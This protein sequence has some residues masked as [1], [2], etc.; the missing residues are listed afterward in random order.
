M[1]EARI[2]EV[3]ELLKDG[4]TDRD[5]VFRKL[6]ELKATADLQA[7]ARGFP[8]PKGQADLDPSNTARLLSFLP[9]IAWVKDKNGRYVAVNKSYC[10]FY[11]QA[12]ENIVGKTD[13]DL[14][15][16]VIAQK[17]REEE[18]QIM[19]NG[20]DILIE[21][22]LD[23]QYGYIW[24][25]K[26]KTPIRDYTGDIVGIM[27]IERDITHRKIIESKLRNSEEKLRSY[28]ENALDAIF[29]IDKSGRFRLVNRAASILTGYDKA[30]LE[31]KDFETL[32]Y[33]G[34]RYLGIEHFQA[35]ISTGS[36][37][38]EY[39]LIRKDKSSVY[40]SSEATRIS[41]DEYLIFCKDITEK[42]EAE[43]AIRDS[44]ERFRQLA[45]NVDEIFWLMTKD[46]ILYINPSFT[47]I[48]G[49][50][51][52]DLYENN[53]SIFNFIY[54]KDKPKVFR[55]L[56]S[57]S[58]LRDGLFDDEIRIVKP[59][60]EIRW[61][62]VRMFPI[63][64]ES[65]DIARIA[66]IAQD[67]TERKN[68]IDAVRQSVSKYRSLVENINEWVWEID[69]D[70][71]YVY[72]S[73]QVSDILG[74][75]AEEVL[76]RKPF[77]FMAAQE[78]FRVGEYL[79]SS[80]KYQQWINSYESR[81]I[82]SSGKERFIETNGS[83]IID[84]AGVLRGYRGINR[85]ISDR[86]MNQKKIQQYANEMEW[87]SWE[88]QNEITVRKKTE[89]E[90]EHKD[91]LLSAVANAG[92]LLLIKSEINESLSEALSVV[93]RTIG[94]DCSYVYE[95]KKSNE[96]EDSSPKIFCST[97][98]NSSGDANT[99]SDRIPSGLCFSFFDELKQD[100]VLYGS[101][102]NLSANRKLENMLLKHGLNSVIVLPI[103]I[104]NE[105]WG[106]IGFN[107][108]NIEYIMSETYISIYR[109][110]AGAIAA[111][112]KRSQQEEFLRRAKVMADTANKAKSEF[113]ANM[114]HEIRTPMNAILGF[115]EL[116]MEHIPDPVYREYLQGIRIG[117]ENLL[118][119]I[120]DILD[121]SKIE[122]GRLELRLETVNLSELCQ[123]MQ[124]IFGLK[125]KE[126]GLT[127]DIDIR[128][129]VPQTVR[130]DGA[131]MRQVLLNLVG[132]AI[133]FTDEGSITI[134]IRNI[135][136]QD[137]SG[138][139]DLVFE[140]TDTGKGIPPDQ[141]N[142]IFEAFRQQ[143]G[144]NTRKYG[145]T[146]LGLTIT[147]RLTE[148]MNG[149]IAVESEV[150]KGSNFKIY[151]YDVE[152]ADPAS[153]VPMV[154][155]RELKLDFKGKTL[156]IVEDIPSNRTVLKGFLEASNLNIIEA[157]NGRD[158]LRQ[159]ENIRPELIL[160][161]MQMPVM[162]G[163]EATGILKQSK[164]YSSI[165]VVALT[166]SVLG[167]KEKD[168][169]SLCDGFLIKPVSRQ[170]LIAE[171]ARHIAFNDLSAPGPEA[172]TET[173]SIEES[174]PIAEDLKMMLREKWL[175]RSEELR[176]SMFIDEIETFAGEIMHIAEESNSEK[177][178]EY[179]NRLYIECETF[180]FDNINL[181]LNEFVAL[182]E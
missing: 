143:E 154:E 124:Q 149:N 37:K 141:Q 20:V 178:M 148:M 31:A 160:M 142:L 38:A 109:M 61:L 14:C 86:I 78:A 85:D 39:Y 65:H 1:I 131:R 112:I 146:G 147:K 53:S 84:E 59:D 169:Q 87:K 170:L 45:E 28:I 140:V 132:N 115:S 21:E 36:A 80:K 126:K 161:D 48:V 55:K 44:E 83:P 81:M 68:F 4:S 49:H 41:D 167:T 26:Y 156:L 69:S 74:Y 98:S 157:E 89:E 127:F 33:D 163:W 79:N 166:A 182:L 66:G 137:G 71:I 128:K 116:L 107:D 177:L 43:E 118:T 29:I 168:I 100:T 52:D 3:I 6:E 106:I 18:I 15:D 104:D 162:D 145:G 5:L 159:I 172:E 138:A 155:S 164:E 51:I 95:N 101:I 102:G 75:D 108:C 25:E 114:S 50:N 174:A 56:N 175:E 135:G 181:I 117:G 19:N 13:R 42:K 22:A 88:L 121:L 30:E 72:S 93:S 8:Q 62:W 180:N 122:S 125:I 144:Q 153:Y 57:Q 73:P 16:Y 67:I 150:G 130:M 105:F 96:S 46:K 60:R 64:S 23:S 152:I 103:F 27:G 134:S 133:K 7:S 94:A 10:D 111:S 91:K 32:L 76:G 17:Y 171:I 113:L 63:Y 2:D 40:V 34:T 129:D 97:L 92:N 77:D 9:F 47:K 119:L 58:F 12:P 165:P 11:D 82:D 54:R 139:V 158:A 90:L 123:E 24:V 179:S 120:N 136:N 35:L 151:L 176:Q 99:A 173:E 70:D 110:F